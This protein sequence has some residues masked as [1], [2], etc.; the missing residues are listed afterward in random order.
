[1]K[2]SI[3]ITIFALIIALSV[4]GCGENDSNNM[5]SDI[6][7]GMQ[8]AEDKVESGIDKAEDKMDN[9]FNNAEDKL[10][11]GMDSMDAKISRDEA[12]KIAL[13]HAKVKDADI[14]NY[15][16]SL[17]NDNGVL[18]YDIEFDHQGYEYD[19]EIDAKTGEIREHNKDKED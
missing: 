9:S 7:D 13:D 18:E 14:K 8:S 10:Q 1:M 15:H 16:I 19:Y 5:M 3:L 12:K 17:D 4:T 6:R 11:N 2:K